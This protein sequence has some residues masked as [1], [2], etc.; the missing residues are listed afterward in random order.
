M[1]TKTKTAFRAEAAASRAADPRRGPVSAWTHQKP[2]WAHITV[3]LRAKRRELLR[4]LFPQGTLSPW[5]NGLIDAALP[6]AVEEEARRE[7]RMAAAAAA[8]EAPAGEER[9]AYHKAARLSSDSL[10]GAVRRRAKR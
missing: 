6:G 9:R 8:L 2:E 3:H 1:K 4:R 10:R 5:I 7:R